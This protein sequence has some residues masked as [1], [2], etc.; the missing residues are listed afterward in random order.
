M[1]SFRGIYGDDYAG[2]GV[3]AGVNATGPG[4]LT[5]VENDEG[6][7]VVAFEKFNVDDAGDVHG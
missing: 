1:G 5:F 7:V 3:N 4:D 2:T 6:G